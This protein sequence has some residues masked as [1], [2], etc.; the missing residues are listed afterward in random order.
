[1]INT[2][3]NVEIVNQKIGN[4]GIWYKV[5][6]IPASSTLVAFFF[7]EERNY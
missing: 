6:E 1:M 5:Y 2:E 7:I 4:K 3:N